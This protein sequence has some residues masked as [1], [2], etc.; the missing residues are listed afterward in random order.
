MSTRET[1]RESVARCNRRVAARF[2]M[3]LRT[4]KIIKSLTQ[5]LAVAAGFYALSLGANPLT[6]FAIIGAIVVGPEILEY[7]IA[8]DGIVIQTAEATQDD[9]D[10]SA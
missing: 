1:N 3:S 9:G 4:Y 6:T 8:G 10:G 7:L 5:L 2:H